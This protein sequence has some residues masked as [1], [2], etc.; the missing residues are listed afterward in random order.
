MRRNPFLVT[1]GGVMPITDLDGQPV[2]NGE[3]GAISKA[4][5]KGY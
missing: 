4:L 2:G 1:A 3:G 5:W